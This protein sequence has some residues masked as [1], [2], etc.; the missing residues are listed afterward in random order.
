[1]IISRVSIKVHTH[2]E[3]SV[4]KEWYQMFQYGNSLTDD[5]V[6]GCDYLEGHQH[7]EWALRYTLTTP[8][9]TENEKGTVHFTCTLC[10]VPF[11]KMKLFKFLTC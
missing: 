5:T 11:Y 7:Q 9:R 2:L 3:E 1:M 8:T 4:F 10:V 6:H